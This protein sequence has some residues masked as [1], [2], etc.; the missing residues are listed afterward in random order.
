[1]NK[2]ATRMEWIDIA[3]GISIFMI[4]LGH[5]AGKGEDSVL[6]RLCMFLGVGVFFFLS[7][8]TFCWKE[9]SAPWFDER[10]WRRFLAELWRTLIF[11]YL[12]WALISIVIYTILGKGAAA[13]LQSDRQHFSFWD[14]MVGML[15]AN[16]GSGSSG[17]YM[18]WNRPLWFL[19]CLTMI[20]LIWYV[21]LRIKG[22][23][24]RLVRL[25]AM[26]LSVSWL[27]GSNLL[28]IYLHLPWELE[29]ACS[30]L[31]CFGLGR[32]WRGVTE[33]GACSG[34]LKPGNGWLR[35][36]A[37]AGCGVLLYLLLLP[38]QKADFRADRFTYPWRTVPFLLIGLVCVI[39]IATQLEYYAGITGEERGR[40]GS[41]AVN[42]IK[43]LLIYTGRRSMAILVTHKFV[44]VACRILAVRLYTS[45]DRTVLILMDLGIALVTVAACLILERI[46][47]V[48]MPWIFGNR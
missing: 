41:S 46:L 32:Y 36:T 44:V 19:P 5:S 22:I 7:G 48:R 18:E 10:P 40:Q 29:T 30:V 33:P 2:N 26:L 34:R 42:H 28:G 24:G 16:S 37:C 39:G 14:N 8:I 35:F 38:E 12:I 4:V 31:F 6:L 9:G 45:S 3:K 25:M 43:N 27:I 21:L 17:G 13:L 11:P 20:K 47:I 23:F 15:Y 1:M